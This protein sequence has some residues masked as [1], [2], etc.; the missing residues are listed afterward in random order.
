MPKTFLLTDEFPPVQT[1]I[2]RLMGE[3]ARRYPK[4][5]L[6]VS[7]GQHRDASETDGAYGTAM[8]DRRAAQHHRPDVVVAAR[9]EP[10]APAPAA[11]RLVRLDPPRGLRREVDARARWNEIRP[12]GARRRPP[13]GAAQCASLAA[14]AAHHEGPAR[15][16]R[17]GRRQQ[18][19]DPRA[20]AEGAARAGPRSARRARESRAAGDRPRAIQAWARHPRRARPLPPQR[21]LLG[22]HRGAAGAA[23]GR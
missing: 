3:I 18:P 20:G 22:G 17:I 23:Q 11:V 21:R 13:Q 8:L 5:E 19:V 14:R 16:R 2:A 1:G 10:R 15:L 12:A 4:G 6:L 9:S 7:T